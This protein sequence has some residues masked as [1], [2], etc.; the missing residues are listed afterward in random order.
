MVAADFFTV[1]S[2]FLRRYYVLLVT[3][4]ERRVVHLLAV[5]AH[6][7]SP[8]VTQATGNLAADLE[9]QGRRVRFLIPDRDTRFTAGFERVVASVGAETIVAPVRSP[10]ANGLAE[11]GV[12][13]AR[14]DCLDRLVVLSGRH[15]GRLFGE[16]VEHYHRARPRRSLD[17]RP[18]CRAAGAGRV[19]RIHRRDV[20]GGLI[21]EYELASTT[22]A[23][24]RT[25]AV[26]TTDDHRHPTPRAHR[27]SHQRVLRGLRTS[28]RTPAVAAGCLRPVPPCP[29]RPRPADPGHVRSSARP[30]RR[31]SSNRSHRNESS[32]A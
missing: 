22:G 1:D 16:Y 30:C 3:E 7:N 15:L 27:R 28:G 18:P 2:V 21:H 8:G 26:P 29:C 17:L 23:S 9:D 31:I 10:K 14:E 25:A 19:G 20:L 12:P 4:V 13:T 24:G 6:A 32:T 5:T 11:R